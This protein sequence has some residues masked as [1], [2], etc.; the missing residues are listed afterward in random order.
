MEWAQRKGEKR[1]LSSPQIKANSRALLRTK[2][3][4]HSQLL[5]L[6]LLGLLLP[7]GTHGSFGGC[8]EPWKTSVRSWKTLE[9]DFGAV[10][11]KLAL[12]AAPEVHPHIPQLEM[13]LRLAYFFFPPM[14]KSRIQICWIS[15]NKSS[16]KRAALGLDSSMISLGSLLLV[17]RFWHGA[18]WK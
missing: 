14:N 15:F 7:P 5:F 11:D 8:S 16:W 17:S 10:E 2:H 18:Y 3:K 6:L 12:Q 1:R 4:N 13:C 9:G